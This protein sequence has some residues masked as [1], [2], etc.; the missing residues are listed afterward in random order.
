M[1]TESD[2]EVFVEEIVKSVLLVL[3]Y[4]SLLI[5]PEL[6]EWTGRFKFL[7]WSELLTSVLFWL[8]KLEEVSFELFKEL[9]K[10]LFKELVSFELFK[11]L[12][13]ELSKDSVEFVVELVL[14]T[15]ENK[16]RLRMIK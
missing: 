14:L 12:F 15:L 13:K 10:E 4:V 2:D 1:D 7:F 6:E 3:L 16:S 11:E 9:L 5:W 8:V